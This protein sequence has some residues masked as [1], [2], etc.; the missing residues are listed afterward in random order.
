MTVPAVIYAAKSTEDV[1]GSVPGQLADCRQAIAPRTAP[2]FSDEGASAYHG[3]RG[4]GLTDAKDAAIRLAAE[5]G[6]CE[7]W[8]QHSDRLARGD[9]ITADHLAEV[10]F[11]L[12]RHGVRLRSVQDDGNLEDIIRV[13][14]IGE[15]NTEDSKRKAQATRDGLKRRKDAGLPVGRVLDGYHA[16]PKTERGQPVVVRDKVVNERVPDP[17]R[18]PV[19]LRLMDGIEEGMTPGEVS[20]MFNA[21]GILTGRGVPWTP[22]TIRRVGRNPAYAGTTGLPPFITWER[23]ER[24]VAM[25]KRADPVAV[26]ARKGGRNGEPYLLRGVAFCAYC[27]SAMVIRKNPKSRAYVCAAVRQATGTCHAPPIPAERL[28]RAVI[29]HLAGF[30]GDVER[31]LAERT[32]EEDT[33]RERFAEAIGA[34]RADLK[35]LEVRAQRA[36]AQ[37]DRLLDAGDDLAD[38]ALRAA[39]RTEREH[40][41]LADTIRHAE[42]QLA[43]M[44]TAPDIDAALDFYGDLRDAIAGRL[45]GAKSIA[46]TNAALRSILEGSWLVAGRD[47]SLFGQF[48]L[49]P[50]GDLPWR[51]AELR[52]EANG[53]RMRFFGFPAKPT[54]EH[55]FLDDGTEIPVAELGPRRP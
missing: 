19:I 53:D 6:A 29:D 5:H 9:G 12:R 23:H 50:V 34:Q 54:E 39:T 2:E 37:H 52:S 49:R 33:E 41:D 18:A 51:V 4:Q 31:W 7:L 26:Q 20:R 11:A 35:R 55:F 14:L 40:A 36:H 25:L 3:N 21:E 38:D 30:V 8:V 1:R 15:R 22:K 28:E 27:R 13:V 16:V 24:I 42:A 45:S 48:D 43:A 10:W 32:R 46:D 47:G 44:P 17:E